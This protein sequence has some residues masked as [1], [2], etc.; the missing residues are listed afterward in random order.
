MYTQNAMGIKNL[1]KCMNA[2]PDPQKVSVVFMN[3]SG[4]MTN[5]CASH[6]FSGFDNL[7]PILSSGLNKKQLMIISS[8]KI[9]E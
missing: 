5:V 8:C 4:Q 7:M 9:D 1:T 6:F 2:R 3:N